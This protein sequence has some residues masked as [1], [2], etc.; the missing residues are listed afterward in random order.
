MLSPYVELV[1]MDFPHFTGGI[2]GTTLQELRRHCIRMGIPSLTDVVHRYLHRYVISRRSSRCGM[3]LKECIE[4][5]SPE[6][7][8]SENEQLRDN[9]TNSMAVSGARC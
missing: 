3:E 7:R 4:K 9:Q 5:R 8:N 2:P 1:R 6:N